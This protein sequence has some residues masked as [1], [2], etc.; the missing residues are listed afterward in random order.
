MF[1]FIDKTSRQ[2]HDVVVNDNLQ[3]NDVEA[4]VSEEY[5]NPNREKYDLI[6]VDLSTLTLTDESRLE[7]Y[8]F[9]D[10]GCLCK[11][12]IFHDS[13]CKAKRFSFKLIGR[14]NRFPL[15]ENRFFIFVSHHLQRNGVV[16]LHD[17][18]DEES[19]GF[20]L[21][22]LP[23]SSTA[24]EIKIEVDCTWTGDWRLYRRNIQTVI[25][26]PFSSMK[27]GHIRSFLIGIGLVDPHVHKSTIVFIV[28]GKMV[29]LNDDDDFDP[30]TMMVQVRQIC[31]APLHIHQIIGS[32]TLLQMRPF[33]FER[34]RNDESMFY[35]NPNVGKGRKIYKIKFDKTR[36]AA[37]PYG[38]DDEEEDG[39]DEEDNSSRVG[40]S[41][42]D[43]EMD[44]EE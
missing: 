25:C 40:S 37:E 28:V 9:N 42:D 12:S 31:K 35:Y 19:F 33:A 10:F 1:D 14:R 20:D 18:R 38:E 36:Q 17:V 13:D 21:S 24:T 22:S 23:N 6:V 26:A 16:I 43:E 34:I 4:T 3:L 32:F 44:E 27:C 7:S 8:R 2:C 5:R 39:E 15:S 41:E 30:N 29:E 11:S